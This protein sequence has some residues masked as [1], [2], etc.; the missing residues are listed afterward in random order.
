[1]PCS[2]QGLAGGE[3]ALPTRQTEEAQSLVF[4]TGRGG[5][6]LGEQRRIGGSEMGRAMWSRWQPR[7]GLLPGEGLWG[8]WREAGGGV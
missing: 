2:R 3:G 7:G 6:E 8:G 1:M 4:K 5:M